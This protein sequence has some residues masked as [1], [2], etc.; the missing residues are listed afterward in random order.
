MLSP[1][2]LL[3]AALA[4]TLTLVSGHALATTGASTGFGDTGGDFSSAWFVSPLPNEAFEGA[5]VTIDAD[6]GVYQGIDD[7]IMSIE[8]FLDGVSI[9]AQDC[10]AGCIFTGIELDKGVHELQLV[11][12]VVGYTSIVT[13]Y[14]DEEIP[15]ETGTESGGESGS[16]SDGESGDGFG[17]EGGLDGGGGCNAQGEPVSPWGLLTLPMLLLVPGI[18]RKR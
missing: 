17:S 8:L 2:G 7:Q 18:R 16:E 12:D 10:A 4:T 5:P 9:G 3:L 15:S 11:A 14:V 6:I 13:V 1:K